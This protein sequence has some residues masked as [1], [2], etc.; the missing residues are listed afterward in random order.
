MNVTLMNVM[1]V[2]Y[3]LKVQGWQEELVFNGGGGK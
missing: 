1:S 3:P 2:G